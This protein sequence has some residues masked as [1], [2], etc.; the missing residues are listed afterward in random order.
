MLTGNRGKYFAIVFGIC[1]RLHADGPASVDLRRPDAQHHQPDPRHPGADIWVMDPSVQ[2][3]DDV[4]PLTDNDLYR[5]RGVP[6]VAWAVPLYKGLAGP[7][8][9]TAISS[10]SSCWAW[11][12]TLWSARTQKC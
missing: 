6:G 12:T 7:S 2:F 4:T 1:L 5:V 10:S 3:I 8:S 11:T 9:R